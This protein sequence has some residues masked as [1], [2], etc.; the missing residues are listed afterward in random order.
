MTHPSRH[1]HEDDHALAGEYVL[2]TLSS[3]QRKAVEARLEH[4]PELQRA[5][6]AWE[7]RFFPYTA[8]V[9]P[10]PPPSICGRAL[11]AASRC[12]PHLGGPA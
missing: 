4:E 9:E 11:N 8:L 1:D 5:V 3:E 7:E 6:A 10:V 12:R 2:G